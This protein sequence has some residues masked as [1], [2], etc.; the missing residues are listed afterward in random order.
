MIDN[1]EV[2]LFLTLKCN[3]QCKYC[4]RFLGIDEVST[5]DNKEIINR[6]A[7]EGIKHITFTGGEPLLY[8]DILELL[9]LAKEKKIKS[10]IITNGSI[11]ADNENNI[12]EIYNYLD[13]ITLSIDSID[14][15][16]NQKLGRGYNHFEN[17]KIVLDSLKEYSLKVNINTVVSSKNIDKIEELGNFLKDYKINAW[18]I[19]KFMPLR[20][21]AKLNQKEFEISNAEFRIH[22]NVFTSFENI[23][24]IEFREE[25]EMESKYILIMPNGDV[26]I[27]EDEVDSKIGNILENSLG[28]LLNNRN[29]VKKQSITRKIRTLVAYNNEKEREQILD[30]IK[31]LAFVEIVG[32]SDGTDTYNKIVSLEPELVFANYN[33]NNMNG[34]ELIRKSKETLGTKMPIFNFITDEITEDELRKVFKVGGSKVNSIIQDINKNNELVNILLDYKEFTE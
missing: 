29:T 25:A 24:N 4:H 11:L 6:V 12:R 28:E 17:I 10:K 32:N 19:F 27:T 23:K 31:K 8:A 18:R 15:K 5:K 16:I 30:T 13:S 9:K 20:E 21:T 1:R 2:C 7:K 26:V 34:I 33:L 3:Q 22:K 14:S